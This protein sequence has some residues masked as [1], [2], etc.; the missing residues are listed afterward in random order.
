MI[1]SI[2]KRFTKALLQISVPLLIAETAILISKSGTTPAY[3][4]LIIFVAAITYVSFVLTA[5]AAEKR[6]SVF[7][8][9]VMA[10]SMLKMLILAVVLVLFALLD[11]ENV[12]R[13]GIRLLILF[14]VYLALEVF[15]LLKLSKL[16]Q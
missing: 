13:F 15:W 9:Y 2:K 16:Q 1:Q 3:L 12:L 8:N 4:L 10:G 6:F 5:G 14:F 11:R 7:T